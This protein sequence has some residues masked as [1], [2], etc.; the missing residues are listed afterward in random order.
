LTLRCAEALGG[1]RWCFEGV[2]VA[3]LLMGCRSLWKGKKRKA[4]QQRAITTEE[5]RRDTSGDLVA[6]AKDGKDYLR[7]GPV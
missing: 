1:V 4:A 7:H 3:G 2:L 5:D 6:C